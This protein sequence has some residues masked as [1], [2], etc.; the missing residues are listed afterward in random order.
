MIKRINESNKNLMYEY[1]DNLLIYVHYKYMTFPFE[2]LA[3]IKKY[4]GIY[5]IPSVTY[6]L[7]YQCR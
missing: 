5:R 6:M 4:Q 7:R 2:I 3:E 1:K